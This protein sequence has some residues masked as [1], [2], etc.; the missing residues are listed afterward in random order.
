MKPRT[1]RSIVSADDTITWMDI[2]A[3]ALMGKVG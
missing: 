3:F 1:I 2:A